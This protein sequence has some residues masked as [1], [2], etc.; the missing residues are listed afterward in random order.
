MSRHKRVSP[1]RDAAPP[2]ELKPNQTVGV[3]TVSN[4]MVN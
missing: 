3:D 2:K 4:L 1:P